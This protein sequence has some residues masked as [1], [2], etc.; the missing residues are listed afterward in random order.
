VN[1]RCDADVV[2]RAS[3]SIEEDFVPPPLK[4]QRAVV[5]VVAATASD[6]GSDEGIAARV[7]EMPSAVSSDDTL[8]TRGD[9]A[10]MPEN[11]EERTSK[12]YYFDSYA[13]H[14]IH[15]EMLKDEVR[16]RTY[17]M[18]ILQN[19]HLFQ[20]KVRLGLC[21][22]MCILYAYTY[23][24]GLYHTVSSWPGFIFLRKRKKATRLR[25]LLNAACIY[26]CRS[27]WM[28]AV[29]LEFYPCLLPKRGRR[30]YTLSTARLLRIRLVSL[31]KRMGSR[32]K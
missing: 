22:C 19:K 27:Y 9:P 5:V 16:T 6:P 8:G 31:L 10:Q 24:S 11:P 30:T 29:E 12:D 25:R 14:A 3:S 15:E 4:K 23:T 7:D 2:N 13:H 20:D 21:V 17:E 26:V 18:A 32:T 1:G 28:L